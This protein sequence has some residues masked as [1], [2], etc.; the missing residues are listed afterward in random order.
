MDSLKTYLL[1][2]GLLLLAVLLYPRRA[3]TTLTAGG[4]G[5]QEIVL[6]VPVAASESQRAAVEQFEQDHP[7]YHVEVGA[8]T[9]RD[10]VSDPTRFLL[11]V[12]GGSPPDVILF[13][14]YAVVEW[15]ARGAFRDLNGYLARDAQRADGVKAEDFFAPMWEEPRFQSRQYAIAEGTDVRALFVNQ[16]MLQ[17]LSKNG[18]S[19]PPPRTWEDLVRKK[20]QGGGKVRDNLLR[21][22]EPAAMPGVGK[23]P[24]AGGVPVAGDVI[25]LRSGRVLFRARVGS[26]NDDGSI[27]IDFSNKWGDQPTAI[28]AVPAGI[29]GDANLEVKIFDADSYAIRLSRYDDKGNLAVAGF[30]PLAGNAWLYIYG[31]QNDATYLSADGRTC[32]LD[33]PQVKVALQFMVDCYDALGGYDKVKAY[34]DAQNGSPL[35]PFL[36]SRIAMRIDGDWFLNTIAAFRPDLRFQV[37]AAPIPQAR[38]QAA[39]AAGYGHGG[40]TPYITWAG[41]WSYAIPS[42]A[43]NPDGAWELIRYLASAHAVKLECEVEASQARAA[44]QLY[45]PR[46]SVLKSIMLPNPPATPGNSSWIRETYL[47][48]DPA[49]KPQL[50]AA[51][52]TFVAL[53]PDAKF[54]PITPVGQKLWEA[55]F[56]AAEQAIAHESNV[57]DALTDRT[58][59]VQANLDRYFHP[60]TGPVVNWPWLIAG[61]VGLLLIFFG[62]LAWAERRH[63]RAKLGHRNWQAGFICVSPWLVG[64]IVFGGGP[65]L[66]SLIISLCK[67]DVL[68]PAQFIGLENYRH[69]LG[70][71]LDQ[72]TS[73][74]TANDPDLWKSLANTAFMLIGVPIGIIAGL[75]IAMLMNQAVRGISVFRTIFYLPSI[76]PSV[77]TFLLWL[78][79]FDPTRGLLNRALLGIG[80]D[81]PPAWLSAAEWAKPALIIMGLWGVGGGM[82]IWLAGLKNIPVQFYEAAE[83]DGAGAWRQFCNVTLPML[84]PYIFFNTVMGIIGTLQ[85]FEAAYIMTD[86]GPEKSTMFYAYYLFNQA[87]RYLDMGAASAMAWVLFALVLSLTLLQLWFSRRWVHYD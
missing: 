42:T 9:V 81:H 54:R 17:Q 39:E 63:R 1:L 41:G 2:I 45:I 57:Y 55:Q 72:F 27:T 5:K 34:E 20:F 77:A 15:A 62:A 32:L 80:V 21:L 74:W 56:T 64:F 8:A 31:W 84:S 3:A 33:Q 71:H 26:V 69:L 85:V 76:V 18:E 67:Y 73:Q 24:V 51:Y 30:T 79:I 43:K 25:T 37:V 12:A 28:S 70:F 52:D 35:D 87:F 7:Q 48:H 11:G 82:L 53:T 23:L 38:L 44:G 13:D 6:W 60:P 19:V 14:R 4:A 49:I 78:W 50:L 65:I 47:A 46:L 29:A 75:A 61:Y 68:N 59:W 40:K 66:F 10:A 36:D 22:G 58:R 16:D 86:G 83:I